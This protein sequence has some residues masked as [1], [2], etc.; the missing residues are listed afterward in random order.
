MNRFDGATYSPQFDDVRLT[1][2][3]GRVYSFMRDGN[4]RTLNEIAHNTGDPQASISAQLRHLRK[5]R[6]GS[7]I[8][9]K[10]NRGERTVGLY[11]YRVLATAQ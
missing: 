5:Q 7:H 8:V 11:E 1:N 10:R 9:E 2:Q 3:L 6:F 4:W